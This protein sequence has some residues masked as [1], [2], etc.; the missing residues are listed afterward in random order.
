MYKIKETKNTT[1]IKHIWTTT[2]TAKENRTKLSLGRLWM[3]YRGKV[4]RP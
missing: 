2:T 4:Y 3:A 1:I